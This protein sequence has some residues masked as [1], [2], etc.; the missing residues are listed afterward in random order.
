MYVSE[1]V[2]AA[3][4]LG[5]VAVQRDQHTRRSVKDAAGYSETSEKIHYTA[6]CKNPGDNN[7][8]KTATKLL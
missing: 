4:L 7:A 8:S 2:Q 1:G 6:S 5:P 3:T